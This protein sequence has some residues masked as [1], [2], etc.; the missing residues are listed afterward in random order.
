MSGRCLIMYVIDRKL[1]VVYYAIFVVYVNIR[2]EK[3]RRL[4]FQSS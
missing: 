3:A 2:C 4:I 1:K